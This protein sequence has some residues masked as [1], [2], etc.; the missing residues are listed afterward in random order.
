MSANRQRSLGGGAQHVLD[1]LKRMQAERPAFF[2]AV[3][4]HDEQSGGGNILWADPV[5]KMNYRI[6]GDAVTFDTTY[7]TNQFRVPFAS[8]TGLN[9]HGQPVLFGCAL[10]LDESD[11]SFVWLFRTWLHA[12]SGSQPVSLTTE[13]DR[14]MQ[15]AVAQVFPQTRHR[16]CKEGILQQTLEALSHICHSSP[17][18]E[19]EFKQCID[20]AETVEEF[21]SSWES[22]VQRYYLIG[23]EWL[24]S[25]YDTRHQ[26]VPVY[27]RN[28]FFGEFSV[29]EGSKDSFF[30]GFVT[31]STTM[32]LLVK[33]YEKAVSNWSQKETEADDETT[34]TTPALKTPS[35]MERQAANLYTKTLFLK[36]Q[37]EFIGTLANPATKVEDSGTVTLYRVAKF[38][39]NHKGHN[40]SFCSF[41]TKATCSC[42][43]FEFSGI[44]C[45]HILAVFRAKNVLQLPPRYILNR[46]TRNAKSGA[47]LEESAPSPLPNGSEESS[48]ATKCNNLRQEAMKYVEDGAK[49][50]YTYN[51]AMEALQ[52]AAMKIYA[53]KVKDSSLLSSSANGGDDHT[54]GEEGSAAP[55]LVTRKGR[56]GS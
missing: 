48:P 32:Q 53:V 46:W 37:E 5:C 42:Q 56:F 29:T 33:Q 28:T 50:I 1:Y 20:G 41:E 30:Y 23:N 38:G 12:M 44:I 24:K 22:L 19:V 43:M 39:E 7:R 55:E 13:P 35:P 10:I 54:G 26:W 51:V 17:G 34:N 15:L 11:S 31:A 2:Y 47:V 6:F 4:P 49:S 3:Q 18:F 52:E 21:D 27:M 25:M 9:H 40:V 36:F 14:V 16:Y 8:F 45:R